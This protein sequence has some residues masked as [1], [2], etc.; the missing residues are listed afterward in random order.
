MN[1][2]IEKAENNLTIKFI[3]NIPKIVSKP[4]L[5]PNTLL[6]ESNLKL[7]LRREFIFKHQ[8]PNSITNTFLLYYQNLKSLK[9]KLHPFESNFSTLCK[10]H[11]IFLTELWLDGNILESELALPGCQFIRQDR[12]FGPLVNLELVVYWY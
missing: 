3:H 11:A 1:L 7:I 4:V 9:N 6:Q 2:I 12:D 10:Y 5:Q 8:D